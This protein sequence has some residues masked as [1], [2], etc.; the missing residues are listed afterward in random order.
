[1][2]Q[3]HRASDTRLLDCYVMPE[4]YKEGDRKMLESVKEAR[5]LR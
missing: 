5:K 3:F 1:M 2:A 4:V